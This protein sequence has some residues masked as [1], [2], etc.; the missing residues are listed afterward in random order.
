M[1][2]CNFMVFWKRDNSR[3]KGQVRGWGRRRGLIPKTQ[4][5]SRRDGKVMCLYRDGG[6][7]TFTH[8]K[9]HKAVHIK[10]N[11]YSM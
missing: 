10:S 4:G 3:E 7:M 8:V 1:R 5:I 9:I 6:Y 11:V 2:D